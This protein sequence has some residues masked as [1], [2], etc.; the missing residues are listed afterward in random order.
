MP[1]RHFLLIYDVSSQQLIEALDLG[2]RGRVAAE[3]Y[4]EYEQ[5]YRDREG[6]EI[7]L[8][9]ADSLETIRRTHAHYFGEADDSFFADL[10]EP[11]LG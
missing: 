7:V 1:L 2:A 6:I 4:S 3:T 8:I 11:Q 5:K 10:L 9:G